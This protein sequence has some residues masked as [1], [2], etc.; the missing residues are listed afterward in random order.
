MAENPSM[1]EEAVGKQLKKEGIEFKENTLTL[2]YKTVTGFLK[3]LEKA[4][5]LK[6]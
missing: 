2:N 1:S 4:G 3:I 5:R 6:K